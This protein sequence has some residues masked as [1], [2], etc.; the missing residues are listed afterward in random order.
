MA[1]ATGRRQL[2]VEERRELFDAATKRQAA[3][4][5]RR[6]AIRRVEGRGW[7]REDLYER[8]G[9]EAERRRYGG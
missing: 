1:K 5:M 4:D 2:S 8:V 3:R 7:K 6:P 9:G